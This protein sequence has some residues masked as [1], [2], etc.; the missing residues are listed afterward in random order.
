MADEQ[1]ARLEADVQMQEAQ[2]KTQADLERAR[3]DEEE[4]QERLRVEEA[5]RQAEEKLRMSS[6]MQKGLP[7]PS[8]IDPLMF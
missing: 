2:E 4:R 3:V 1:I 7:R 5:Q 6:V 8:I